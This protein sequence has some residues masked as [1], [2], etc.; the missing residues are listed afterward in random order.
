MLLSPLFYSNDKKCLILSPP[1]S[2]RHPPS[3]KVLTMKETHM[4]KWVSVRFLLPFRE[5]IVCVCARVCVIVCVCMWARMCLC[6]CVCLWVCL[7]CFQLVQIECTRCCFP[8]NGT[9]A[10]IRMAD[11]K[12]NTPGLNTFS[13]GCCLFARQQM[14]WE[15]L[16]MFPLLWDERDM[17]KIY[18]FKL[19]LL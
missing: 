14:L 7:I 10:P 17:A 5:G 12:K 6:V 15:K 13:Y 18:L 9:D 16:Q 1:L 8:V 11:K 2:L 4:N 19:L 3:A